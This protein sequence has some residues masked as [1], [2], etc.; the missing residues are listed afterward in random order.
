MTPHALIDAL[1][2][3]SMVMVARLA[4]AGG[5]RA[6]LAHLAQQVFVD[7]TRELRSQG[8][9]H[10]VIADMFGL[11]LRAYHAKSRRLQD[12]SEVRQ[13]TLWQ[14]VVRFLEA[15]ERVSRAELLRRF[16]FEDSDQVV[17]IL[18]DLV[19]SGWVFRAGQGRRAVYRIATEDDL[20]ATGGAASGGAASGGVEASAALVWVAVRRFGPLTREALAAKMPALEQTSINSALLQLEEEQKVARTLRDGQELFTSDSIFIAAGDE[21]G[22]PAALIDHHLAVVNSLCRRLE[23]KTQPSP[24]D[25]YCGGSTYALE[26]DATHPLREE[27]L[28]HFRN[29]RAISASL[30]ER[31]SAVN[32]TRP[33]Q[34]PERVTFYL[35]QTILSDSA[36]TDAGASDAEEPHAEE[37]AG[38]SHAPDV[39][40]PINVPHPLKPPH[41]ESDDTE[42]S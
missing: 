11:S 15:E 16:R 31:V 13:R 21:S 17:G 34:D 39:S 19:S 28:E 33:Q 27:V 14:E 41:G 26:V 22:V 32:A 25:A 38:S 6:P 1:L 42:P 24:L 5:I 40:N 9:P 10:K 3:Q 7:A 18:G 29:L 2:Q 8:V 4:T 35:G 37:R 30:R 23:R 36:S 12:E 20:R